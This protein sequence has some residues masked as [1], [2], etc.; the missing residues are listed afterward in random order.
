MYNEGV[1]YGERAAAIGEEFLGRHSSTLIDVYA[2]LAAVF[3]KMNKL[4]Q[5][6]AAARKAVLVGTQKVRGSFVICFFCFFSFCS[7]SS[8]FFLC[9]FLTHTF[10]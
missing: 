10:I 6:E 7:S 4:G 1:A 8:F 3:G 5:A 2:D 9:S